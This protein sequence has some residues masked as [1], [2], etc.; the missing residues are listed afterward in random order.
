M[1]TFLFSSNQI[2]I[3]RAFYLSQR[4]DTACYSCMNH[5]LHNKLLRHPEET[6]RRISPKNPERIRPM[7]RVIQP[8]LIFTDLEESVLSFSWMASI[9][10]ASLSLL[11]YFVRILHRVDSFGIRSE[12]CQRNNSTP[13]T[14][15]ERRETVHLLV[16]LARSVPPRRFSVERVLR[17]AWI[18][19]LTIRVLFLHVI[20][21]F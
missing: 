16:D 12:V 10:D 4:K 5:P 6:C 9:L 14:M 7:N 1:E 8:W 15:A 2:N 18:K 20:R 13:R 21:V 3:L 11:S 19:E 17:S